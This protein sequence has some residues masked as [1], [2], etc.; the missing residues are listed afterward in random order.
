[1]AALAA[2]AAPAAAP[3]PAAPPAREATTAGE[4]SSIRVGIDK[5]DALIDMMGELVITQSMLSD[6][7]ENFQPSQLERLREGLLQ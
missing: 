7:G 2:V 1:A 6:I 3:A 4:G 5:V